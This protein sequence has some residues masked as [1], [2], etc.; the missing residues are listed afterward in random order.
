M[1]KE[2]DVANNTSFQ[3]LYTENYF[4]ARIVSYVVVQMAFTGTR[5]EAKI[6]SQGRVRRTNLKGKWVKKTNL[7]GIHVL[8]CLRSAPR[9]TKYC[10][11]M[12]ANAPSALGPE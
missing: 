7:V 5:K 10:A 11:V 4:S 2:G 9:C 6:F 12:L 1:D 3:L 8:L